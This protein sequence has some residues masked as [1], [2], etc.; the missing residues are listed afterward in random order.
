MGFIEDKVN[1]EKEISIFKTMRDFPDAV[2]QTSAIQSVNTAKKNIVPYLINMLAVSCDDPGEEQETEFDPTFSGPPPIGVMREQGPV[3]CN[4]TRILLEILIEFIPELIRIVKE[5]VAIAIREALSCGSDFK[6]P[7]NTIQIMDLKLIDYNN[8]LQYSPEENLFGGIFYGDPERDFNRFLYNLIQTPFVTETWEGPNGPILDVTFIT[9]GQISM[10]V[11]PNYE[12]KSFNDFIADYIESIEIFNQKMLLGNVID[13]FFSNVTA[14]L[15]VSSELLVNEEKTNKL[16]E[17]T[18]NTDPCRDEIVYDDSFF[19]FTNDEI[20]EF[21]RR[22]RE[23]KTGIVSLDL[24]CGVFEYDLRG[25]PNQGNMSKTLDL[26]DNNNSSFNEKSISITRTIQGLSE[27]VSLVSVEN[28]KTIEDKMTT[29]MCLSIPKVVAKIA[30]LTPKILG[31][32]NFSNFIVNN[33]T[34]TERNSYNWWRSNRVFADYVLRE[35]LAVLVKIVFNKLKKELLRLIAKVIKKII[36][37]IVDKKLA[38]IA[39]FL[40]GP[41]SGAI[42]GLINKIPTPEIEGSK[43][44]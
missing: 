9:P 14:S 40:V 23:R 34:I 26:L 22:A 2:R 13:N 15:D 25:S 7:P 30:I 44:K 35:S 29:D 33:V 19:S 20:E 11:N 28:K 32:Y 5:A 1:I 10:A 8:I 6:I 38:I 43:Y 27:T 18:L 37:S 42:S 17:K 16:I 24:G 4:A 12:N 41:V 36:K 3:K 21:E 31:I 39:S